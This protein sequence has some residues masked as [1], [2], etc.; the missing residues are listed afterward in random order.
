MLSKG[1]NLKLSESLR[2]ACRVVMCARIGEHM[3]HRVLDLQTKVCTVHVQDLGLVPMQDEQD[4]VTRSI[5]ICWT[6]CW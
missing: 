6:V 4:L 5:V 3:V 2:G 1:S